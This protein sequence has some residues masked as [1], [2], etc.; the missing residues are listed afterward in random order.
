MVPKISIFSRNF[1]GRQGYDLTVKDRNLSVQEYIEALSMAINTLNIKRSR[2]AGE[3]CQGCDHCCAERAPLTSIDFFT[4]NKFNRGADLED[5][6]RKY[7]TVIVEG[8]VVDI[9]LK[10]EGD[11]KCI[12]L[13]RK[14]KLCLVYDSR[15]FVCRTFICS[16]ATY[17]ALALREAIVN[18]GEDELVR[19][20]FDAGMI[21]HK[22]LNPFPDRKDWPP[23]TFTGKK[24]YNEIPLQE[25]IPAK[26][27]RELT[28]PDI[29]R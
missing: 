16:P 14:T 12:F 23:N 28:N 27:W 11:N 13:D 7:A 4:L 17:R 1:H 19:L 21:I 5:F 25:V 3:N 24:D 8:P 26:L 20:W 10:R 18:Q 22:A 2:R 15:P 29:S 9:I 6:L